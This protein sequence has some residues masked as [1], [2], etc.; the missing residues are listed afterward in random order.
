[1]RW[2]AMLGAF[3]PGTTDLRRTP[4]VAGR[5]SR[6]ADAGR[7]L[8]AIVVRAAAAWKTMRIPPAQQAAAVRE[9]SADRPD[10]LQDAG[11]ARLAARRL[12]GA[13]QAAGDHAEE[14]R[15]DPCASSHGV[16]SPVH[17]PGGVHDLPGLRNGLGLRELFR[18]SGG[19]NFG[20][21]DVG[22]PGLAA[23]LVLAADLPAAAEGAIDGDQ[24]RATLPCATARLVLLLQLRVFQSVQPIHVG[25]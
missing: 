7:R 19:R 3:A 10:S 24:L 9:P 14:K 1:M 22:D 8:A 17:S 11:P 4:N 5:V 25:L 21:R 20:R 15:P 12:P 13:R 18:F 16:R 6:P 23:M 2:V